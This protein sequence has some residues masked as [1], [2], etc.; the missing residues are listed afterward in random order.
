MSSYTMDQKYGRCMCQQKQPGSS[1]YYNSL[2]VLNKTITPLALA[3]A[4]V[5]PSFGRIT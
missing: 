2:G 1:K 3:G 5:F 4:G